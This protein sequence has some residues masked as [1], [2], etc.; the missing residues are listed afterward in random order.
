MKNNIKFLILSFFLFI[1]IYNCKTNSNSNYNTPI[2]PIDS[3]FQL[4]AE[5]NV[6]VE[7][8]SGLSFDKDKNYFWTVSDRSRKIYKIDRNGMIKKTLDCTGND[9]EG[10]SFDPLSETVW[11]VEEFLSEAVQLD[12]NGSELNRIFISGGGGSNGLEGIS[13]NPANNH[14]FI[15]KE[16]EP[17]ILIE[18]D[19]TY[20]LIKYKKLGFAD[21]FSGIYYDA[22][23]EQLWIVSDLSKSVYLCDL[24]GNVLREFYTDIKKAE[25]IVVDRLEN[26]IYLISDSSE[27]LYIYNLKL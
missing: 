14:L 6:E 8:P 21:D 17:A 11:I 20:N 9:P 10:V 18:L 13:I 15:V 27:K 5:V 25:G 1:G 22:V 26:K 16:Q 23:F 19:S 7:E 12:T 2:Q 24:D 4:I 3:S